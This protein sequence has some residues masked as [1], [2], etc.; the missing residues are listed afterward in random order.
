MPDSQDDLLFGHEPRLPPSNVEAEQALLGSLL[1]NNPKTIDRCQFLRP[2][3]FADPANA[4][5]FKRAMERIA[6]GQLADP[7][8]LKT[9]F[10][11]TGVLEEY[12]GTKYLVQLISAN[13]GWMAT[14][15][16][17]R[18]IYDTWLRRKLLDVCHDASEA[19]Y[20]AEPG[21]P[22]EDMINRAAEAVMALGEHGIAS[23]TDLGV[24][25]N[26]AIRRSEAAYKGTP[27]FARLD[28]GIAPVDA[29]WGGLW[30]G[31]LY[32]LM[33]RSRTGKTP[34]MMQLVRNVAAR[35]K[36][37]GQGEHVHVFSLEMTAE[38]LATI[39]LASTTRWT[40]D[41]IRTGEID[42][43]HDALSDA[44]QIFR[45]GLWTECDDQGVFE[46]KATTLK[47]RLR[48]ASTTPVEPLLEELVAP[49]CIQAFDHGDRKFGVVRN[50]RQWQRPEKP[51][52]VHPLPDYLK[53]F[54]G[55]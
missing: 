41:Q 39:N 2:E 37:E 4:F 29:L 24:A 14:G 38:D 19:A 49:D 44:A 21:E 17:A 33:A 20:G 45:I 32:Y 46:W 36:A 48:G 50:F 42:D 23:S 43:W 25:V 52:T 16:Y 7:V 11:N 8:T 12:G 51:R 34:F 30:P 27:G 6:A 15:D 47:M 22:V 13:V 9:D 54:V 40:S 26:G 18:A 5:I 31:Q 53:E 35:L 55:L 28:T 10:E 3:H 1:A